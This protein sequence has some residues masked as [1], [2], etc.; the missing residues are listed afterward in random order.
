MLASVSVERFVALD[1]HKHY[2]VVGAVK[3]PSFVRILALPLRSTL[4]VSACAV[5]LG[6]AA[7]RWIAEDQGSVAVR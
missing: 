4:S 6:S 5:V 3:W 1:V 7:V 2:V